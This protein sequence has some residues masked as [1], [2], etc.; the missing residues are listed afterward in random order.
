MVMLE[1]SGLRL[2]PRRETNKKTQTNTQTYTYVLKIP[3]NTTNYSYIVDV[4]VSD[5]DR[6]VNNIRIIG[7]VLMNV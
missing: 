6:N 3:Q 1:G 2:H 4:S 7:C 5:G